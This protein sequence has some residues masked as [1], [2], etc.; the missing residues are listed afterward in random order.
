[1]QWGDFTDFDAE[2]IILSP[3]RLNLDKTIAALE[4][5]TLRFAPIAT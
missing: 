4:D 2:Q 3:L 5:G 1:M